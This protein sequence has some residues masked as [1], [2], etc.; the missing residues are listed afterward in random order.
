MTTH[1]EAAKPI[2]IGQLI[3]HAPWSIVQ[4]LAIVIVALAIVL[5]GFANQVLPLSV[6]LLVKVWGVA[7]EDFQWVQVAGFVGMGLGTVL[8][9]MAGD[10]F[11]RRPVLMGCVL[12]FA[13]PTL[14]TAFVGGLAPFYLLRFIDGLGLGGC[15]PNATALLAELTPARNRS[16]AITSV[17]IGTPLGG[18]LG[19]F[20]AAGVS[21]E[22][23]SSLYLMSGIAPLGVAFLM[24]FLLPESPRYLALRAERRGDFH[25]LMARLGIRLDP[26]AVVYDESVKSSK[27][28]V[29]LGALFTADLRRDTLA[30]WGAMFFTLLSF[31]GVVNWL[32]A[33]LDQAHYPP[34]MTGTGLMYFNLG[35]IVA[36]LSGAACFNRL[37]SKL[38]LGTLA[39][40]A[41]AVSLGL[42]VIALNPSGGSMLLLVALTLQGACI[43]GVQTTLWPLAASVYRTDLRGAGIGWASGIGRLGAIISP[44]VGNQ[45]LAVAG[46]HG[47][48]AGF[49]VTMG[50]S[51]ISILLIRRHIQQRRQ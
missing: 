9:G 46:P 1:H 22:R 4:K 8:F 29:H 6:P 11:G 41:V 35:G 33:I 15:L 25:T 51:L 16:L 3:N 27:A 39:A 49:A 24:A 23:W 18:T 47:Y 12:L 44:L 34:P 38:T 31:Y 37:G 7:R 5:D 2:E 21:P 48:F 40:G 10:R 43:N 50:L 45:L 19:G 30:L 17:M 42:S 28:G 36:A 20:I 13:L 14:A 32:P 26:E